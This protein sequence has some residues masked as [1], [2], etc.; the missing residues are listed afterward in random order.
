MSVRGPNNVERA[1]QS[2]PT[3]LRYASAITEQKKCWE[4]L[5]EKFYRFQTLR[6]NAQQH[7]RTC[8]RVCKRT[9]DVTSNNV[10][11]CWSTMLHPFA[12]SLMLCNNIILMIFLYLY[13][14]SF[15]EWT[16]INTYKDPAN[17]VSLCLPRLPTPKIDFSPISNVLTYPAS[18][19][20]VQY[21]DDKLQMLTR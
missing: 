20:L 21:D 3:L 6:N 19:L 11:S 12:G 10:G 14:I 2:D 5:P 9:Q 15:Q 17:I 7:P 18:I 4:L 8:N 16:I 1:V 13:R